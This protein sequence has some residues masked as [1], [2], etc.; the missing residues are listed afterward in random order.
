MLPLLSLLLDELRAAKAEAITPHVF[1][2]ERQ[3]WQRADLT[4]VISRHL[5]AYGIATNEAVVA[6]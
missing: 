5:E 6:G 4:K 1:P 3:L 2:T